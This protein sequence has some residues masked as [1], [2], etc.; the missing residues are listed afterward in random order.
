MLSKADFGE[1]ES[2]LL[3]HAGRAAAGLAVGALAA[4]GVYLLGAPKGRRKPVT[5]LSRALPLKLEYVPWRGLYYG[6][7]SHPGQGGRPLLFLHAV[8]GVSSAHEMRPL[9]QRLSRRLGDRP[10]YV[11]E[12]LGFGHSDRPDTEYTPELFEEQLEHFLER[13]VATGSDGADVVGLSMGAS[14]AA[15]LAGRR[16]DLIHCLVAIEPAGL[17]AEP[18]QIG[19]GWGRLLFT[20]PGVQR[21]FFD[22]WSKPAALREFVRD[23]IFTPEFG[24]P[25]D[26][27]VYAAESARVEGASRPFDDFL[28]GRLH[29]DG[30]PGSFARLRQP[31]LV[32]HGTVANRRFESYRELPDLESRPNATVIPLSTGALP[33]WERP[34]EVAGEIESFLAGASG[35]ANR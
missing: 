29:P 5:E 20:L 34:D 8:S 31:L 10:S 30:A 7:Y 16:P 26:F 18:K 32:I 6:Y 9:V 21:A 14:Y 1:R 28:S 13:I 15:S 33:H 23:N 27:V 4:Y 25:D 24:V 3:G 17:G 19:P 35:E 12:W 22:R 2:S 11:L